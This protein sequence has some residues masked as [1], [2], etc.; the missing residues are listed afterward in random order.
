VLI[1]PGFWA[2]CSCRLSL[3]LAGSSSNSPSPSLPIHTLPLDAARTALIATAP[4]SRSS[5]KLVAALVSGFH[6]RT[7]S[8]AVPSHRLPALSAWI[9][10]MGTSSGLVANSVNDPL[11]GSKRLSPP[12]LMASQ[13]RSLG[14]RAIAA[15]P[16]VPGPP[17]PRAKRVNWSVSGS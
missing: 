5:L 8:V 11:A 2:E 7:P 16:S 3:R 10:V 9:A 4:R 14:S 17:L 15:T 13:T 1:V 12:P 6:R